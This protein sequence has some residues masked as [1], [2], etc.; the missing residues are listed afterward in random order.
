MK[1]K[2]GLSNLIKSKNI[3][4]FKDNVGHDFVKLIDT[5]YE[6]SKDELI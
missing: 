3:S 2:G 6:K 1:G 4:E 5:I